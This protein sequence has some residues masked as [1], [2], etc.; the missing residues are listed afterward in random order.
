MVSIDRQDIPGSD[1]GVLVSM[2]VKEGMRVAKGAEL[3]RVDDREAKAQLQVKRLEFDVAEQEAN[4]DIGIRFQK[5]AADVNWAAWKKL[6][7]ANDFAS[8][9]VSDIEIQRAK[10]EYEKAKLGIEKEK[11]QNISNQLTAK[12]K[13]AEVDAAEVVVNRRVLQAPFD[14]IVTF[15][16]KHPGEWIAVGEPVVEMVRVD[17]LGVR[18]SLDAQE[19][20]AADI[21]GRKVTVEFNLPRGRVE[22]VTGKVVFVSPVVVNGKLNVWAEIETPMDK[23][24]RPSVPAGMTAA[25]TVHTGQPAQ[26]EARPVSAPR[27]APASRPAT[28]R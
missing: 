9:A 21:D 10:L 4:S 17:R 15:V 27:A 28:K 11:E 3:G 14:G 20:G 19:W 22:K 2:A 8:K 1:P 5:A 26:V 13:K 23:Q 18:G 25:M 12:A 16:H 24:G 6:E 7:K